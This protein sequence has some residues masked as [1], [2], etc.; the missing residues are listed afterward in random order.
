MTT[1]SIETLIPDIHEVLMKGVPEIT[2]EE[3]GKFSHA[4][5]EMIRSRLT[6]RTEEKKPDLYISNIGSPCTRKL[7]FEINEPDTREALTP[8][9]KF[10][11]L[12]GDVIELLTLFLAE[13]AGHKVE[14]QQDAQDLYG[15]RGRRDVVLDG[16][17]VDVKSA[18]SFSYKK[19]KDHTLEQDDAFGYIPQLQG[20]LEVAQNDPIVLEKDRAAFLAIDK[21][22][23]HICLDFH[24]RKDWDWKGIVEYKRE[25]V[26][27]SE[28]PERSFDPVPDGKSG[29]MK[30]GTFCSYCSVK[31][32]CYGGTVREFL[33]STGPRYLTTVVKTPDV[34]E[35]P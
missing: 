13:L 3:I 10:K 20:Y 26:S 17:V 9:T 2:D 33:Y 29:N 16:V 19:F 25:V 18:S 4:F 15:V 31:D 1:K 34:Y 11:F 12:Y 8:D 5:G 23:G 14:G 28:P 21:T 30:L 7:W 24:D 35:V 27:A 32:A 6:T 22:L